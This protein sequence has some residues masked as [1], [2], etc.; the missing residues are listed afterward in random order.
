[1]RVE[2]LNKTDFVVSQQWE[3]NQLIRHDVYIIDTLTSLKV[4]FK[5]NDSVSVDDNDN[6]SKLQVVT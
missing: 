6:E 5:K 4:E 2:G 1:M 3:E